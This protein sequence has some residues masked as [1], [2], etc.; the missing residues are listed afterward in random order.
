MQFRPRGGFDNQ[1]GGFR[2]RGRGDFRPNFNRG[3]F[4][5]QRGGFRPRGR[6]R[7]RGDFQQGEFRPRFPRRGNFQQ[8]ANFQPLA[9]FMHNNNNNMPLAF[10]Q[11]DTSSFPPANIPQQT[12]PEDTSNAMDIDC[13]NSLSS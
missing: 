1:R 9:P 13:E 12:E 4:D 6:G 8:N 10:D 3:G 11:P 2:P 5:N 7:G